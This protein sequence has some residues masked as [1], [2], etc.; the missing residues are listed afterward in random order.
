M[1][2][3]TTIREHAV[4]VPVYG[5]KVVPI[6][7]R[8]IEFTQHIKHVPEFPMRTE[9]APKGNGDA[10]STFDRIDTNHDGVISRAEFDAALVG[11]PPVV[12]RSI[13]DPK[14]EMWYEL[15]M[16]RSKSA[17]LSKSN[18]YLKSKL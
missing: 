9:W 18:A 15:S 2:T 17:H 5:E 13:A 7:Q 1:G 6:V 3:V 14:C 10:Q 4:R 8:D 11:A 16:L 12:G